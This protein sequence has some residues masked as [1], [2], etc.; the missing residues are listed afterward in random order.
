MRE[1]AA[2]VVG[3]VGERVA[4]HVRVAFGVADCPTAT[5]R[6]TAAGAGLIAAPTRTPWSS[7][8]SRLDAPAGLQLTLFT[9]L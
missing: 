3:E 1:H 4:G 8:N 7:L 9:D 2:G 6:L 5:D